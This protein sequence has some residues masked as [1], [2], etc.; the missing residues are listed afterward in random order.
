VP[1]KIM[2]CHGLPDTKFDPR[3]WSNN[4]SF[5]TF[6][7]FNFSE[8][9]QLQIAAPMITKHSTQLFPQKIN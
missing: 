9:I 5:D 6:T 1:K 4:L 7:F 8:K 2:D 3:N